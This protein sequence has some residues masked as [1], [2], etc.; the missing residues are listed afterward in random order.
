MDII[1]R[2]HLRQKLEKGSKREYYKKS[3]N[4]YTLSES[5]KK[6]IACVPWRDAKKG[7][8]GLTDDGYVAECLNRRVYNK[9]NNIVFPFGQAFTSKTSKG[10]LEYMPHKM[11]GSYSMVSAKPAW[12]TKKGKDVYKRFVRLYV[13]MSM[14]GKVDY[15]KLGKV[16][17]NEAIPV[18]KAKS[19]LKKE[20]VQEMVNE[21]I[22]KHL[23]KKDIDE[24]TVI[25]MIKKAYDV[26]E[27]KNDPSNMLRAGENFINILGMKATAKQDIPDHMQ[28]ESVS[29]E[30]IQDALDPAK[31]VKS[32]DG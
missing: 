16:L 4:I 19:L 28:L 14:S 11:T 23:G 32:L 9:R 29:L 17:G 12:M 24:G 26:A 21:E 27:E 13:I 20:W 6:N 18:A 22:K 1:V 15:G 7:E 31:E 30:S 5:R 2:K 8:W 25:D 3:Y 10:K